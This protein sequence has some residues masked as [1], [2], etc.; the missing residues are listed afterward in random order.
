MKIRYE[1]SPMLR[2]KSPV[3]RALRHIHRALHKEARELDDSQ[4]PRPLGVTPTPGGG[5]RLGNNTQRLESEF[6]RF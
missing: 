5:K 4:H 6:V 1:K 3:K 2:E